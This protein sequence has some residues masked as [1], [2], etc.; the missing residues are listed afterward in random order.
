MFV[1]TKIQQFFEKKQIF[2]KIV[3]T[4]TRGIP[5]VMGGVETH[6]EELFPRIVRKGADVTV[7]RRASYVHDGLKEW[8]GVQL[9]DITTPK[10]KSF[11]A[12]MHTFKAINKAKKLG[13]DV[14]HI[15][16]IG[17][18]MLVPYARLLGMKVVFT[19]HGPD[20]DRDKWGRAAKMIL[21]LGER[22][23]CMFADDVIV[24][25]DVI[26]HLVAKKY[27]RT[28][29]VH[30]IY[31]G[32]PLPEKCDYPNYF[33]ELGIKEGKYILAMCRFVPE[34]NL[35][36]LIEAFERI[37]TKGNKLV[38]AGDTDFEDDYSRKLKEKARKKGVVLTGFIKGKK[39]HAL[40]TH[41]QCFCLPSSHEGLPIALLEA[42][43]YNVPVIVSD[44]PANMEVGLDKSCY[45]PVGNVKM[46]SEKLQQNLNKEVH[47]QSYDMRKYNWDMIAN[48]IWDVYHHLLRE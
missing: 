2:M 21:K 44:I 8:N 34:K 46:L 38:L 10:K 39:L 24:I 7:I 45:F 15:H 14:L 43:S 20:Y 3:V 18:A 11:E 1:R 16:A 29:R 17:P 25:S 33:K 4:G 31:N 35:H 19:H 41:C 12:I 40:L 5:G 30:L 26:R 6:C 22:M 23:G 42:M 27:D 48:Q 32:V 37:D 13:A 9:V 47:R 28:E 36:H